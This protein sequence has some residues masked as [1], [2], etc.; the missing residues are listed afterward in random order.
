LLLLRGQSYYE[1]GEYNEALE[2]FERAIMLEPQQARYPL[3]YYW[4]GRCYQA[5]KAYVKATQEYR[6]AAER[7]PNPEYYYQLGSC[8]FEMGNIVLA[9]TCYQNAR[10]HNPYHTGAL[11]ELGRVYAKYGDRVSALHFLDQAV[12]LGDPE[13]LR[14]R[15]QLR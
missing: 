8:Y 5:Q 9:T 2:D 15:N 6:E 13:A 1:Q 11:R 4:R 3:Y 12:A 7:E 14:L 10:A